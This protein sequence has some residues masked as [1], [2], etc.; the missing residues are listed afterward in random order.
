[1]ALIGWAVQW[2][3]HVEFKRSS[4]AR[5]LAVDSAYVRVE[6]WE[7]NRSEVDRRHRELLDRI[8]NLHK[9]LQAVR[10]DQLERLHGLTDQDGG[11]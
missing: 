4:I 7:D 6:R 2:G 1:M 10:R 3:Q 9:S 8:E 11:V 5:L